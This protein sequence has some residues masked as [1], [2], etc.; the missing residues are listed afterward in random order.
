MT[1]P[2]R[3]VKRVLGALAAPQSREALCR[4]AVRA[5]WF[6][7]SRVL[8]RLHF[9]VEDAAPAIFTASVWA[10]RR[11]RDVEGPR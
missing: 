9:A 1:R 8:L 5:G 7:V 4:D 3:F 2:R 10:S 11:A 6:G